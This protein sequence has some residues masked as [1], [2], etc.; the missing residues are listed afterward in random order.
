MAGFSDIRVDD[1]VGLLPRAWQPY[2]RLMRLDRAIGTWLLL[3]PALWS[4]AI[5]GNSPRLIIFF[6]IGALIMRGAG[7]VI[8][9]LWDRDIDK[10][11]ERTKTRPLASGAVSVR[12]AF[13]LLA[14]LLLIGFIIVLQ[15]N[16]LTIALGFASLFL[17][18]LYPL[19]KRVTWWP[20]AF[21]GF[22]F[23]WGVLMGASAATNS[24]PAW[25]WPLYAAGVL[26]TL[27]Y[28]TIYAHADTADD[29]LIGVKSTAR[30]LGHRSKLWVASFYSGAFALLVAAGLTALMGLAFYV[31]LAVA[32]AH[33]VWTVMRWRLDDPADC[34]LRFR[35][36]RFTGILIYLAFTFGALYG[37]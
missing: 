15:F 35:A 17:I 30:H 7:C 19:M 31:L 18:V 33:A 28:D 4:L 6:A 3:L 13:I 11:V 12:Q 32:F 25:V 1:W 10:Q 36:N 34:I 14:V 37:V 20:Q 24:L 29:A 16:G 21:L 22:T 26:W 8:N 9:D 23:N 2:A 27:G 5:T